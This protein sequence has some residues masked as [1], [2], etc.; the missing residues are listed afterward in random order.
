MHHLG[1]SP[2]ARALGPSDLTLEPRPLCSTVVTRFSA[3]I[4]LSDFPGR[5]T[6]VLTDRR[7]RELSPTHEEGSPVLTR[8]SFARMPSPLPR[9]PEAVPLSLTSRFGFGLLMFATRST[10]TLPRFRG[11]LGRSLLV[12]ACAL[13]DPLKGTF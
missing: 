12:R 8:P 7:L 6:R 11:L 4:G 1:S 13:T 3:L 2:I 10:V 9:C 5:P